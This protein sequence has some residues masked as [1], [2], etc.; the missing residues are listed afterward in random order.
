MPQFQE[1]EKVTAVWESVHTLWD[2][3]LGAVTV[4]TPDPAMNLLLNRWLLYQTVACRLWGCSTLYQSSGAY[5][6]RDQLQ[7]VM[8]VL[9][10]R[11]D[12]ARSHILRAAQHQFEAGDVLHWWHPPSGRGV[13]TRISDDLLWL[14]YVTAHY[15]AVTGD[16]T[17]LQEKV[18]FLMGVPLAK[19]E[20]ERYGWYEPTAEWYTL[21]EHCRRALRKG[22]TAGQHGLPRIGGGDWNDGMNRVGIEGRGE[23]VWLGWFLYS[24]LTEFTAL[25]ERV[26]EGETDRRELVET[27]VYYQQAVSLRQALETHE[28][29]GAWYRRAYDDDGVPLG[30]SQNRECQI[31]ALAQS[32]AVLSGAADPQRARQAMQSAYAHLVLEKER[33]ILLLTPP[34]DKT[35]RDPGYINTS[36]AACPAFGKMAANTATP[37]SGRFGPL[38]GWGKGIWLMP[39]ST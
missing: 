23:S 21:L 12:L 11:S 26:G 29:D 10:T 38:P 5:G 20:E 18:P 34:F 35:P 32:W 27:A 13:R 30:S 2:E 31:D 39:C 33:L 17:I 22:S 1:P 9:H 36:K 14:P 4:D 24:T 8:A 19:E 16:E 15:A 3:L 28:W 25:C 37:P 6:F 7:D